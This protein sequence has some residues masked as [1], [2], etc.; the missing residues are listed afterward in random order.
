MQAHISIDLPHDPTRIFRLVPL[1]G[2]PGDLADL[3]SHTVDSLTQLVFHGKLMRFGCRLNYYTATVADL[4]KSFFDYR[5]AEA[6]VSGKAVTQARTIADPGEDSATQLREKSFVICETSQAYG[7]GI[8]VSFLDGSTRLRALRSSGIPPLLLRCYTL[9]EREANIVDEV[10]SDSDD[11]T[12]VDAGAAS[13]PVSTAIHEVDDGTIVDVKPGQAGTAALDQP[14]TN[15][16]SNEA[17]FCGAWQCT[18]CTFAGNAA[19]T[20]ACSVCG[21]LNADGKKAV[22][23]A[24][25]AA[26]QGF[27]S[28]TAETNSHE[29]A[30]D[31]ACR[32]LST[33]NGDAETK[34]MD[35]ECIVC[36]CEVCAGPKIVFIPGSLGGFQVLTP[37]GLVC[38]Q[39]PVKDAFHYACGLHWVCRDCALR[40]LEADV[41]AERVPRCPMRDDC[42]HT[43]LSDKELQSIYRDSPTEYATSMAAIASIKAK[44]AA[45]PPAQGGT[46]SVSKWQDGEIVLAPISLRFIGL[47]TKQDEAEATKAKKSEE[48]KAAQAQQESKTVTGTD[49]QEKLSAGNAKSKKSSDVEMSEQL[50][51][52][53]ASA[54][55]EATGT[56]KDAAVGSGKTKGESSQGVESKSALPIQQSSNPEMKDSADSWTCEACTFCNLSF[57]HECEMCRTSNPAVARARDVVTPPKKRTAVDSVTHRPIQAFKTPPSSSQFKGVKTRANISREGK[58]KSTFKPFGGGGGKKRKSGGHKRKAL[59]SGG[60]VGGSLL[61]QIRG[62]G[63]KALRKTAGPP[64]PP[65]LPTA[66]E[67]A[68]E[69]RWAAQQKGGAS[70]PVGVVAIQRGR[71]TQGDVHSAIF[72]Q[73]IPHIQRS[74][75][76]GVP[77]LGDASIAF[78]DCDLLSYVK[79]VHVFKK[80]AESPPNMLHA[81]GPVVVNEIITGNSATKG[82]GPDIKHS[83]RSGE[84]IWEFGK[85]IEFK[86]AV[87]VAV[88]GD[89]RIEVVIDLSTHPDSDRHCS[90]AGEER[91]TE[92][93]AGTPQLQANTSAAMSTADSISIAQAKA[94][95][96]I[97]NGDGSPDNGSKPVQSEIE[98]LAVEVQLNQNLAATH[99]TFAPSATLD[100]LQAE[101]D[102]R[103]MIDMEQCLSESIG[104]TAR[105]EL[106]GENQWKGCPKC[107]VAKAAPNTADSAVLASSSSP[108]VQDDG[109]NDQDNAVNGENKEPSSPRL[110][111]P[112][113]DAEQVISLSRAA[114]YLVMQLSRFRIF[115]SPDGKGRV[116]VEKIQSS[117]N[118]PAVLDIAP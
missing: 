112:G 86:D 2:V 34:Y 65:P 73:F 7:G 111:V 80:P 54:V 104:P 98:Q 63:T 29:P 41:K 95:N 49:A 53:E 3:R 50:S 5:D 55:A 87:L 114:P 16:D 71:S 75:C 101:Q 89:V 60:N 39:V 22:S 35:D 92:E 88:G 107:C 13:K 28:S 81:P 70:L 21:T 116:E 47:K 14:S 96:G 68:G 31:D 45:A 51:E 61:D 97:N 33:S 59:Y 56:P 108:I 79:S 85:E 94:S 113:V 91:L 20:S 27:L 23:D 103:P 105:V 67:L 36:Y 15:T 106:T 6:S 109:C 115:A 117:V 44:V 64:P 66:G 118:I 77:S 42:G 102:K 99:L 83:R 110:T 93:K 8:R 32:I 38:G 10:P 9:P 58:S 78:S 25:A 72:D 17:K 11:T 69:R 82:S 57:R 52:T 76:Q 30:E 62:A 84:V 37:V 100:S 43:E 46:A 24:A 1:L 90:G 12:P 4:Q 48:E 26:L 40:S 19:G 18:A 74:L